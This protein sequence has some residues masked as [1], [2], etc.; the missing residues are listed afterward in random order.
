MNTPQSSSSSSKPKK[1][2]RNL[3]P[4]FTKTPSNGILNTNKTQLVS[5]RK[6][7]P[8]SSSVN[9]GNTLLMNCN[10]SLNEKEGQTSAYICKTLAQANGVLVKSMMMNVSVSKDN[11]SEKPRKKKLIHVISNNPLS[12]RVKRHNRECCLRNNINNK[13]DK[14]NISNTNTSSVKF[15]NNDMN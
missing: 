6:S 4:H 7:H 11:R 10:L 1:D 12:T 9:R 15:N 2:K 8:Q 3:P 5:R 13:K 14:N